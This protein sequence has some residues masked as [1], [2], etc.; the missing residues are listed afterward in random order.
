MSLNVELIGW[1]MA[2]LEKKVVHRISNSGNLAVVV[3]SSS[4]AQVG[5]KFYCCFE[6]ARDVQT[7]DVLLTLTS[8]GSNLFIPRVIQFPESV[9]RVVL[10]IVEKSLRLPWH[11]LQFNTIL[12]AESTGV[13]ATTWET[14]YKDRVATSSRWAA[15]DRVATINDRTRWDDQQMEQTWT[16]RSFSSRR[17]V[18]TNSPHDLVEDDCTE[19]HRSRFSS[20]R[21]TPM[22]DDDDIESTTANFSLLD[23]IE[24]A[25]TMGTTQTID[26][27]EAADGKRKKPKKKNRRTENSRN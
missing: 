16:N 2:M 4:R 14:N 10:A 15:G 1:L 6:L 23:E 3:F 13:I 25:I 19:R 22:M 18:A 12:G 5:D 11:A 20:P 17:E 9:Q 21:E 24:I 8:R 27:R 7:K 26:Q